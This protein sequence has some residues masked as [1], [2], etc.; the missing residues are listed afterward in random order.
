MI[1]SKLFFGGPF[2]LDTSIDNSISSATGARAD[3]VWLALLTGCSHLD[4]VLMSLHVS[5]LSLI[6]IRLV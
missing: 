6:G 1:E 4:D 2:K 5:Y 3:I